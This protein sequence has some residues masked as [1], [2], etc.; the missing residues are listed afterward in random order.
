ME[1]A[2]GTKLVVNNSLP[3]LN[4]GILMDL[5]ASVTKIR[6]QSPHGAMLKTNTTVKY[7]GTVQVGA[8]QVAQSLI[9]RNGGVPREIQQISSPVAA[10]GPKSCSSG[11]S[12][13]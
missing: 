1:P 11:I 7:S 6:D 12:R 10:F 4:E 5:A 2:V 8:L 13:R 9:P 3:R